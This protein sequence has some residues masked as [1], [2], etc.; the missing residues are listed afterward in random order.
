VKKV[1]IIGSGN[2]G[3]T[4]ATFLAEM[5]IAHIILLDIVEG[6]PQGKA[7][8]ALEASPL[9]NFDVDIHGTNNYADI[10]DSDVVVV[11]AG[12]PRKPGMS[13]MDL[14]N[15]N[16]GIVKS[17]TENIVKYAPDTIIIVV[18]NPLD[19]MTYLAYKASGFKPERVMGQAGI[20]DSTRFR[21]FVAEELN[22][23][24]KDTFAM[25]LGSHGDSMVPLPEYTT[26]SGIPITQLMP[27]ERIEKLVERTR[28]GGSEIVRHLKTGSAFYAPGA[29]ASEMVEAI[30]KDKHRV[31]PVSAYLDGQYG[32]KDVY[33]GVPVKL[34]AGGVEEIIEIRLSKEQL[35]ALHKSAD[36]FRKN[37]DL[38]KL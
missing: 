13:R 12:V 18:T 8:D 5:D 30:I 33:T 17:V 4:T 1:S 26:V 34:G 3:A 15:V 28:K 32:L 6:V 31:L 35:T 23:S 21:F 27:Q 36:I 29:A 19:V 37:A 14:L 38:L 2:V 24:L 22:I 11:T 16:A 25:V 10:A 9:R 7:L 20:L